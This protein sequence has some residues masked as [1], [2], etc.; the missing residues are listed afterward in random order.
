[1]SVKIE[2]TK[3]T[4]KLARE[5]LL[6][7]VGN[8]ALRPSHVETL[9]ASFERGEYVQTHQGI[10]FDTKGRLIDGQHRLTAIAALKDGTFPMFVTH[11]LDRD[12]VFPVTDAIQA[13]RSI[14]DVLQV[15]RQLGEVGNF[16]AKL[17]TGHNSN[18][19]PLYARQFVEWAAPKH[20]ALMQFCPT[21]TRAWSSAPVRAAAVIATVANGDDD[22]VKLVY[23]SL[24]L[25]E[26]DTMP[27]SA[28]ALFRAHLGGRVG[29]T[30][31]TDMFI[32]CLKVFN[33]EFANV[34][35]VQVKDP[36]PTIESVRK[37]L[38]TEIFGLMPSSKSDNRKASKSTAPKRYALAGLA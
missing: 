27:V 5:Y 11:G 18:V 33:A 2:L 17:Y 26:F 30:R 4:P 29:S 24:V 3:V 8:R 37:L 7:N 15:T 6:H 38:A 21:A 13:K 1:M 25:A 19:T 22:Y 14:A 12:S 10:A 16:L 9:R 20:E 23:R 28:Q 32:R 34:T 31:S 35:R 36:G